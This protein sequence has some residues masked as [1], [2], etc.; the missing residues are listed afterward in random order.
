LEGALRLSGLH[1]LHTAGRRWRRTPVDA[2][3]RRRHV[4]RPSRL[5]TAGRRWRRTPVDAGLRRRAGLLELRRF[6]SLRAFRLHRGWWRG[7]TLELL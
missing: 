1:R 2:G 4:Q 6:G 5:H 3:L 7:R